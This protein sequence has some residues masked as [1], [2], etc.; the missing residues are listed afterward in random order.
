VFGKL[1][2]KGLS[3]PE[4][5]LLDFYQKISISYSLFTRNELR[6]HAAAAAYYMLLSMIPM[7]LVLFYIF[8]TF[9]KN[10]PQFSHNLFMVLYVFNDN[11][12]Y[13]L[14]DKF[15]ISK[16][17]GN[18]I[19]VFGVLNLF[20]SSRLILSSV[21]RAFGVIFPSEKKRNF[22]LM[23]M[24]SLLVVP[25]VFIIV[26][27]TGVLNSS[28]AVIIEYLHLVGIGTGVIE[29]V[30]NLVSYLVPAVVAFLIVFFTYRYLPVEKP[31]NI[32]ALKGT[33]LFIAV[34]AAAR[35]LFYNIFMQVTG[36]SA[37]GLL[38]SLIVVLVWAYFVFLLYFFCAQYVFV[39][40]RADIIVLNMLFS[41]EGT[42]ARFM[43]VNR[44][45][46]DKY[47]LVM[48]QGEV[49]FHQG[50]EPAHVFYVMRG[51]LS[52]IVDERVVGT[53]AEGEVLGE[54]AYI[55]GEMRNATVR[56]EDTCILIVI[57]FEVFGELLKDNLELSRRMMQ[58]LCKRLKRAQSQSA[59][60][61]RLSS[62]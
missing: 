2:E 44:K 29:P 35:L 47:S 40:Y 50:D 30:L 60:G 41:D 18:A 37:Y 16:A 1:S 8:D 24:I 9:L 28:R 11:L 59:P 23:N 49:L 38:G 53:I 7:V 26:L 15:G 20:L 21:Q 54:T 58:T 6:N 12:S 31:R 14:F 43:Q 61:S 46:L 39:S 5:Y 56:A 42:S 52:A 4:K 25:V 13:D 36:G 51:N 33:L 57:P 22:L 10:Y 17:A 27:L 32:N 19:G 45:V 55:T 48:R 3:N 34:F 62:Q